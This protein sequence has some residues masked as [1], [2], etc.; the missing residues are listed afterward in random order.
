MGR[1]MK[2]RVQGEQKS[3]SS[4]SIG[5]STGKEKTLCIERTLMMCRGTP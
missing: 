1:G 4:Q 2:L 3:D 5:Q